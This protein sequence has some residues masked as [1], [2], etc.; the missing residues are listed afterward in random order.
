MSTQPQPRLLLPRLHISRE[1]RRSCTNI[2]IDHLP[3]RSVLYTMAAT[4]RLTRLPTELQLLIIDELDPFSSLCLKITNQYFRAIVNKDINFQELREIQRANFQHYLACHYCIRLRPISK[5]ADSQRPGGENFY[6]TSGSYCIEC[7]THTRGCHG[8]GS[9]IMV[10]Q[11][12]LVVC[13][14]CRGLWDRA[15]T[16]TLFCQGCMQQRRIGRWVV[17]KTGRDI[18][19]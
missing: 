18:G 3:H 1:K 6:G 4:D 17:K 12:R 9:V 2:N 5:F 14:R 10:D 16:K 7:G 19:I 8:P 13:P 11:Q 15:A